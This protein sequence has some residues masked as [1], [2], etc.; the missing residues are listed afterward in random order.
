M[1][2]QFA[3]TELGGICFKLDFKY[4]FER[5]VRHEKETKTLL[6]V[7]EQYLWDNHEIEISVIGTKPSYTARAYQTADSLFISKSFSSP[8]SAKREGIEQAV[9]YLYEKTKKAS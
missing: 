8:I 1:K 9:K 3:D 6:S 7:I 4:F 2:D 5:T